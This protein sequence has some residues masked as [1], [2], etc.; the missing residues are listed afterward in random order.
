MNLTTTD[1]D[2]CKEQK[3]DCRSKERCVNNPGSYDCLC[4]KGYHMDKR[5][6]ICVPDQPAIPP[7]SPPTGQSS[8]AIYLAVGEYIY[9]MFVFSPLDSPHRSRS[10]AIIS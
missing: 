1:I 5:E 7:S 3:N 2:E 8:L 10:C 4:I 6:R 9:C